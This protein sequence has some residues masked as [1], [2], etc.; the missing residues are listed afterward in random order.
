M[1]SACALYALAG[2]QWS[3]A[4]KGTF[5]DASYTIYQYGTNAHGDTDMSAYSGCHVDSLQEVYPLKILSE[6]SVAAGT[7][8]IEVRE[9]SVLIA[10]GCVPLTCVPR[11]D[12]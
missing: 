8:R 2:G 6:R 1:E 10:T 9:D 12:D 4:G 5:I 3:F 11:A 7:R